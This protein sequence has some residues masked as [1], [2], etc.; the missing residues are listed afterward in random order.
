AGQLRPGEAASARAVVALSRACDLIDP[1]DIA[2]SVEGAALP[3]REALDV[4]AG[5]GA[6][7]F[8][9]TGHAHIDTAWLWPLRET[10]R[11]CA[12]TFSSAVQLMEEYPEYRFVCS[13]PQQWAWMKEHYPAL[14][15]RMKERVATGQFEPVGGMWVEADCNIPSGESLVRQLVYGKR[16]LLDELG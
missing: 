9:A 5:P 2:G 12:R 10:V 8:T 1:T 13:Q 15:A 16:F 6:H 7:R 4:P 11:K 3:L 14:F